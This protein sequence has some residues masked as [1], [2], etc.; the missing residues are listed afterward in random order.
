M[1]EPQKQIMAVIIFYNCHQV[2]MTSFLKV[3]LYRRNQLFVKR[4]F[5]PIPNMTLLISFFYYIFS[6]TAHLKNN[7]V[8]FC[9]GGLFSRN[10]QEVNDY[11]LCSMPASTGED[12][13]MGLSA[14]CQVFCQPYVDF[15]MLLK[16]DNSRLL[17]SLFVSF[18]M[19]FS[20]LDTDTVWASSNL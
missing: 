3:Q 4:P 12:T 19:V 9:L 7:S 11:L 16:A 17:A 1:E 20:F 6:L 14:L 15:P 10:F 8:W 2:L 13:V 5:L 18:Q